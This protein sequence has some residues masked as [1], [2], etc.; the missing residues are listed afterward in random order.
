MRFPGPIFASRNRRFAEGILIPRKPNPCS[1]ESGI[2]DIYSLK[3]DIKIDIIAHS[4]NIVKHK[5][6]LLYIFIQMSRYLSFRLRNLDFEYFWM[7]SLER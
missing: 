5:H 4:T 6:Y 2:T 3:I 7:S 1:I